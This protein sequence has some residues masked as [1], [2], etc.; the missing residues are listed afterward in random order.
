MHIL[1]IETSCDE[2]ATAIYDS[3]KGLLAHCLHSQIPIHMQYGG[4]VP[5]L[6][7][8]DHICQT[9]PLINQVLQKA[10]LQK[11]DIQG[12]AF[13]KGPGLVGALMVGAAIARSLSWA[14]GIPAVGVNHLEAHL[15][16]VMLEEKRPTFPFVALLV[17]G[18]H[19]VLAA[20]KNFGEYEILGETLDDAV[21]EAFD[22]TA[23]LLGLPYPGGAALSCLALEGDPQRFVFP[24]PMVAQPGLDF[25]FS[26]LKTFAFNCF[27][28]HGADPRTKADIAAAF[29]VAVVDTLW[30]K[31]RRALAQVNSKRLVVA[32][33]V[34]ANQQLR[35]KLQEMMAEMAGEVYFPRPDFCTDN[36]AMVAYTGYLY[37]QAGRQEDLSIQVKTR[38][39]LGQRL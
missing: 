28:Q 33:G 21:G 8:R 31:C 11:K 26:G 14:W 13:T 6:A 15:M 4:V 16:A 18:G 7:S 37:L 12:I 17:S 38:W 9:L 2:T 5:E 23:K 32:G 29:Q 19:T 39:P 36:G 10:Q 27:Q 25:S 24:K 34:G 3:E 30:I 22:K 35:K 1:G 20:V